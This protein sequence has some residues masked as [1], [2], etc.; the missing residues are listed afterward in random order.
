MR[1]SGAYLPSVAILSFSRADVVC[2]ETLTINESGD[3][4]FGPDFEGSHLYTQ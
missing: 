3:R 2:R 4:P 1:F